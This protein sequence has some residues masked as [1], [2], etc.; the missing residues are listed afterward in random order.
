LDTTLASQSD[1]V[2]L[3]WHHN[4]N[5]VTLRNIWQLLGIIAASGA[6]VGATPSVG[7]LNCAI[8]TTSVL[9]ISHEPAPHR[10]RAS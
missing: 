8:A 9:G 5:I 2:K 6:G 4:G 1:T 7:P 10:P 3:S